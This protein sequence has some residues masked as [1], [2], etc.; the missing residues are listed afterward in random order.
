ML[1]EYG[2]ASNFSLSKQIHLLNFFFFGTFTSRFLDFT[3]REVC[4]I[5]L[6]DQDDLC[7]VIWCRWSQFG[8][9]FCYYVRDH[10]RVF[11][12]EHLSCTL[13][14]F[15]CFPLVLCSTHSLELLQL[16]HSSFTYFFHL[17]FPKTPMKTPMSLFFY[18]LLFLFLFYRRSK[19]GFLI[20]YQ[21]SELLI[22]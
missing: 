4:F 5:Y 6:H 11:V 10:M 1:H 15:L 20:W 16:L 12:H 18:F 19:S 13:V 8:F 9:F 17:S 14:I 22:D 7:W 2:H 3:L 21:S